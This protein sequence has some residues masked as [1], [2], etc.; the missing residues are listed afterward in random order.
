ML[1]Y[2][3]IL[4]VTSAI[5]NTNK[6]LLMV[7]KD[8]GK[9]W[10]PTFSDLEFTWGDVSCAREEI[11]AFSAAFLP[12]YQTDEDATHPQMLST[13]WRRFIENFGEEVA[14]Y[15]FDLR[16][17]IFTIAGIHRRFVS[18]YQEVGAQA[19]KNNQKRWPRQSS[20]WID[21]IDTYLV[22]RFLFVDRYMRAL[23]T[24]SQSRN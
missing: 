9:S 24:R 18:F 13:L 4:Y 14:N 1:N 17:S 10:V 8:N 7:T 16:K 12:E 20:F 11:P 3:C 2:V 5:D 23:R 6:N 19:Y 21:Q 22:C 15:W